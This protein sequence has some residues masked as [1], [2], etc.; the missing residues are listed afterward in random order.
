M[1]T[2]LIQAAKA[3][4]EKL[5]SNAEKRRHLKESQVHTTLVTMEDEE[6][7]SLCR[8]GGLMDFPD[9]FGETDD[10]AAAVASL[11]VDDYLQRDMSMRFFKLP[12]FLRI[13]AQLVQMSFGRRN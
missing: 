5:R 8:D 7:T 10:F 9:S 6:L 3:H 12:P 2:E 1:Y 11:D 13:G 4:L